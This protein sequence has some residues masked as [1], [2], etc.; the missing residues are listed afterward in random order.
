M[1]HN[2][3]VKYQLA[4]WWS[5]KTIRSMGWCRLLNLDISCGAKSWISCMIMSGLIKLVGKTPKNV[6]CMKCK[7][8]GTSFNSLV[9]KCSITPRLITPGFAT[10]EM[11]KE[12]LT[13]LR[14]LGGKKKNWWLTVPNNFSWILT[15]TFA[16]IS[17]LDPLLSGPFWCHNG[18]MEL[19]PQDEVP[20]RV[21]VCEKG[22][23][24]RILPKS[25]P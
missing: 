23:Y 14:L 3:T 17:S 7:L 22:W 13:C 2:A 20:S 6:N 5:W 18:C 16:W 11:I 4:R 15:L 8:L 21:K 25:Y 12:C 1:H 9:Q 24:P 19:P 10:M